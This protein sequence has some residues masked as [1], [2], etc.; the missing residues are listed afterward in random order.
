M[1]AKTYSRKEFELLLKKNGYVLMRYHGSHSIYKKDNSTIILP[2]SCNK[3]IC[4]RLIKE[5]NLI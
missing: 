1:R 4:R 2:Y 3:M 5:N